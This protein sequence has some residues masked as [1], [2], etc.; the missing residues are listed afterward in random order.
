ML[1]NLDVLNA[2]MINSQDP[3]VRRQ[4]FFMCSNLCAKSQQEVDALINA[5]SS[6]LH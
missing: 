4:M 1:C 2:F 5:I 3:R 6:E